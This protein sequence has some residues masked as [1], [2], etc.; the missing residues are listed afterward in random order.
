MTKK[1]HNWRPWLGRSTWAVADQ[2]LFAVSSAFLNIL[3]ARWLTPAEYG[4]FAIAYTMFLLLGA[5][6]T[7]L[8][9]EPML[10]FG[11]DKYAQHWPGYMRVLLRGHWLLTCAGSLLLLIASAAGWLGGANLIAQVSL[12]LAVAA[13]FSLLLWLMRRTAYAR[14]QPQLATAASAFYLLLIMAGL[15]ALNFGQVLTILSVMLCMGLASAAVGIWL[16]WRLCG[17]ALVDSAKAEGPGHRAVLAVHWNYGRWALA[18]TIL[19]WVPLNLFFIVLSGWVSLEAS[20]TLK[21]LTNVV[22]PLMQANAALSALLLPLLV[23][24]ACD[25][26]AFKQ[27]LSAALLLFGIGGTLYALF[28][29]AL[30]KPLIHLLYAGKYDGAGRLLWALALLPVLDGITVVLASALRSLERP[31]LIFWANLWAG[32]CVLTLGVWATGFWGLGGAALGMILGNLLA[33][34]VLSISLVMSLRRPLRTAKKLQVAE[35]ACS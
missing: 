28:L 22:L 31:K 4:A 33:I 14:L 18:T 9:T 10:V 26:V 7:A 11:S 34:L 2:G 27:L 30:G 15:L 24:R 21:A 20:A 13:P 29:L 32:A 1:R 35:L 6:H 8:V 3:L 5:V 17:A 25:A 16:R 19:M 12:G 23:K